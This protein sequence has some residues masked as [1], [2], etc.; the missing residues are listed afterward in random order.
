MIRFENIVFYK[1][2]KMQIKKCEKISK[3]MQRFDVFL[4][5]YSIRNF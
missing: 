2:N 3:A 1:S 5:L 4:H